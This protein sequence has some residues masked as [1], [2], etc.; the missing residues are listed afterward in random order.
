M[1]LS[2]LSLRQKIVAIGLLQVVA[3][4]G[5][6]FAMY[7]S[8]AKGKVRQQYVERAR[9][10]ILTAE[11]TREGMG[12]KW[13]KG[14][15]TAEQLRAWAD[16][17]DLDR[18]LEAVP[19][20]TAWKAAMA[21]SQ[22]GGYEFRAIKVNARNPKNEPDP[23]EA[24]AIT[25]MEKES[26]PEYYVVD[27]SRNAVRY[28]RPVKLTQ[29]C[30]LCHGDPATSGKLWGN[31]QGIDPSGGKMENWKAGEIHGAFEVIQSLDAADR[32]VASSMAKG[33]G[34]VGVLVLAGSILFFGLITRNVIRPVRA[35]VAA[36][37]HIAA[38][39]LTQQC[40]VRS[41]D[42]IGQ[43]ASSFN[44]MNNRLKGVV[45][46]I[47]AQAEALNT[48]SRGLSETAA[49]L[50][51]GANQTTRQSATVAAAAEELS[52]NMS[53]MATSTEQM[54]ANVKSVATATEE[55]TASIGEMARS[56]EKT[57]GV[58]A[59][60]AQLTEVGSASITPLGAAAAEIGEVIEV[61][62][63]VAEQTN[64]LAL[65]ATIEAARAGEAGKGFA[66]VATEVKELAKQTA[67]A[68]EDIRRKIE[69][70]QS[71]TNEAVRAIGQIGNVVKKTD[72]ESRVIA[73]AVEEQSIT[74]KEIA[75]NVTETASAADTVARGV[76]ETAAAGRE[77]TQSIAAVDEAAQTTAR[78]ATQAQTASAGLSKLAEELESLVGQFKV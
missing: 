65:N 8:D 60:A 32:Q 50:A 66:V 6:L 53:H 72:Q 37:E 63:D 20:V 31:D 49:Q 77:I 3:V 76:T 23:V 69:G 17:K 36:S 45:G 44:V 7:H 62:Q 47:R 29:E 15:F 59:E 4:G 78:G 71:S 58:A 24:E 12:T 75:K 56:A 43:L 1:R 57:A 51:Q 27:A 30:L 54:S 10:I 67:K 21:K 61:I 70:M 13:D 26:L 35:I 28:F 25:R 2:G 18:I 74:T 16:K 19:V 11:A 46:K 5:V 9:S 34:V 39:D 14:L 73:S 64:L 42:E 38:G 40:V 68:T 52:V 55:M 48:A 41:G 22:E 33:A